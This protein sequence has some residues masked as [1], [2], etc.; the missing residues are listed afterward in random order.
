MVCLEPQEEKEAKS[1]NVESDD[2]KKRKHKNGKEPQNFCKKS[3]WKV[4]KWTNEK[5]WQVKE[6]SNQR[7]N[8]TAN[9]RW[10]EVRIR[11]R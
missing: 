5:C 1:E 7:L 6:N 8:K 2:S 3:Q 11:S 10:W 9:S 4:R